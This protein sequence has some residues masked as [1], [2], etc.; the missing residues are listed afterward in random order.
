MI[1][2][3]AFAAMSTAAYA[4]EAN[5]AAN[6]DAATSVGELIVTGSRIPQP[7][8]TSVSPVTAVGS[9]EI[10]LTGT[11][12]VEDLINN[13]P[14]AIAAQGST[15]SNG[16]VGVASVNLRNLGA[17][18]TL[19]L[20]DGKRIGGGDPRVSYP[21]LNS[22]PSAL[23]DRIEIDT[24]GASAVYGS[25]AIAGV[26]NFIMKRNFEGV[27]L[28]INHSFY[29]HNNG[30]PVAQ[31]A[32][33]ARGFPTPNGSVNDGRTWDA[34]GVLGVNAP[35]GK[36]NVTAYVSY[37][38]TAAILQASRDFSAC[39]LGASAAGFKC[40]G[41]GTAANGQFLIFNQD[42]SNQVGDLTLDTTGGGN[43]LRNYNS[44][45]DVFNYAPYNYYQRPDERYTAGAFAHYEIS[46]MF[47][48]YSDFMF[49]DDHTVAQ[50][51]P[52]G[53]FGVT[54]ALACN[55]PLLSAQ[56]VTTICTNNGYAPTDRAN[57]V[58]LKRNVE[59]GGRRDDLRHT[60]Y[61]FTVG[62]RGDL[63]DNWRYDVYGQFN[64]TIYSEE[65]L[66]D[67]S[68]TR[69]TKALD[70]VNN[71]GVARCASFV[72]GSDPACVPYNLWSK[73][74]VTA[75]ALKYL[76][77]PG[78][79]AGSVTEQIVSANITGNLGGYGVK[80]P[81]STDGVG[82]A[83]GAE[84]R[85]EASEL[86]VDSEFDSGDL[87]G[88][89]GPT[90]GT[91][92]AYDVKELFGEI[93]VPLAQDAPFAKDLS[94]EAGFRYSDYSTSGGVN[95]YKVGGDWAITDWVRLRA[96]YNRAVRAP[97]IVELFTPSG[98][99]LDLNN[100]NCTGATPVF[101]AVQCARTGVSAGQY[102]TLLANPAAQ[103]NGITGGN[104][105]LK[106]ETADTY[107]VGGVLTPKDFL[108]G[109]SLSIDYY[110]IN[111]RD[112]I[113]GLGGQSILDNCALT[114]DA[115][116]CALVHRAP[117][118]GS[119]WI[120]PNGFVV[121][122]NLNVGTVSTS[123]VDF[124]ANYRHSFESMGGLTFNFVGS[125]TITYHVQNPIFRADCVGK[126]GQTC[127][128]T[129][130]PQ[131]G[132]SPSWRHKLR[133]T[134]ATPWDNIGLSAQWRYISS[135]TSDSATA[136]VIDARLPA[137]NYFDLSGSIRLRDRY[138]FRVGINNIFDK[139]PP[140]IGSGQLP[141][142]F[143]NGNTLPQYYDALGRYVFIGMTADF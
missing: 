15:L 51:A 48:A 131:T 21:D 100:D 124:E 34:T 57:V 1:T 65:Y 121:D 11:T 17:N 22:I 29:S 112:V 95:T 86:R 52:S 125:N 111:I 116:L 60:A 43:T 118:T 66:N 74:G 88:Q 114:G 96:G 85:R 87:A 78:F 120:G 49:M 79:Q 2:G 126:Y 56:E 77:T 135:I 37:R 68:I 117:G 94:L 99:S 90:H 72:D 10:K 40:G 50:I 39:S 25:D 129:G 27:R 108:G 18:R 103:Y 19:V 31:A 24:G 7:N 53:A 130:T 143:G 115:T 5:V 98:L 71:G 69:L 106:P 23:V 81:W 55:N 101:T 142:V 20:V 89:G 82:I 128:G 16:S 107:T 46:K 33:T 137:F 58:V 6:K 54:V 44:T 41:S 141:S 80:S 62:L 28:D 9:T 119:L 83:V 47:D 91:A 139:D 133:V 63:N 92:G 84:Y 113:T 110:K 59:G 32:T 13:L 30:D 109:F 138:N 134:W 8:L 104:T 97:N 132:P 45:T 140:K 12:K 102:G 3:V 105:A 70:V 122:T 14:Q 61:R 136:P 4:A 38:H 26:V 93:R 75:A 35:D 76:Q 127:Q 36:G 73:G 42:F 123:G 64:R 67:F